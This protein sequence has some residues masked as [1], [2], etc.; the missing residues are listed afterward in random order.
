M[1]IG[2]VEDVG[3][4]LQDMNIG[5]MALFRSTGW[6]MTQALLTPTG[7]SLQINIL[8]NSISEMSIVRYEF[9]NFS[10]ILKWTAFFDLE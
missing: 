10:T 7:A 3:T 1:G 6:G 8:V 2:E 5:G 4:V 9:V